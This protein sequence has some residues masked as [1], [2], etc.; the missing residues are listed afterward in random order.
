MIDLRVHRVRRFTRTNAAVRGYGLF[1]RD[2]LEKNFSAAGFS[3]RDKRKI[4]GW[5]IKPP[6]FDAR[7]KC[8]LILEIPGGRSPTTATVSTRRRS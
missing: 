4:H 8:P 5:I 2:T 7:R 6:G 1:I 3:T